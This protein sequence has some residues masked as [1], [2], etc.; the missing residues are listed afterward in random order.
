M[1]AAR[2][3]K[4][5]ERV[6]RRKGWT[7]QESAIHGDLCYW[8]SRYRRILMSEGYSSFSPFAGLLEGRSNRFKSRVLI[9]DMTE[10]AWQTNME[11]WAL[12]TDLAWALVGRYALPP[13]DEDGQ[14]FTSSEIGA[15]LGC[16]AG[17][18]RERVSEGRRRLRA[19]VFS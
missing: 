13:R 7:H 12:P 4:K 3:L 16:S 6:H 18:Y 19:R 5:S 1:S 17:A 14:L 8:G 2:P 11:V 9:P 15:V 10:R